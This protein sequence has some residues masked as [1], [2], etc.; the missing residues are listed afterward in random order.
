MV[1]YNV[2]YFK[3]L[4]EKKKKINGDEDFIT[5]FGDDIDFSLI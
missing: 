1:R 5:Y 3:K 2:S 4:V